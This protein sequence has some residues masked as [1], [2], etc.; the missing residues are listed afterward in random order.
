MHKS[1]RPA[2]VDRNEISSASISGVARDDNC[3]EVMPGCDPAPEVTED[4]YDADHDVETG[5]TVP[6]GS[7]VA[8][9][10]VAMAGVA[11]STDVR[12]QSAIV[13]LTKLRQHIGAGLHG[14]DRVR[15][16]IWLSVLLVV[17]YIAV[18]AVM[19]SA[20]ESIDV[21]GQLR[22]HFCH[23]LEFSS[24]VCLL[25]NILFMF[26]C[27]SAS[28]YKPLLSDLNKDDDDIL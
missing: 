15:V 17:A 27:R 24:F 26:M 12:R 8:A 13:R 20:W 14:A 3:V 10:G 16:P 6:I 25:Y 9:V 18:G 19:F 23:N 2:D 5:G 4:E 21:T 1:L 28:F 22:L 7:C 11:T